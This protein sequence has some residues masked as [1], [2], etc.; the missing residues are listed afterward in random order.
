MDTD[1]ATSVQQAAESKLLKSLPLHNRTR[2]LRFPLRGCL[3]TRDDIGEDTPQAS[4]TVIAGPGVWPGFSMFIEDLADSLPSYYHRGLLRLPEAIPKPVHHLVHMEAQKCVELI[5]ALISWRLVDELMQCE[6]IDDGEFKV[7][8]SV[9][10]KPTQALTK[11]VAHLG[12]W[13]TV[14]QSASLA[15]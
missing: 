5:E 9:N 11:W 1:Y 14:L 8:Y 4:S 3:S 13:P 6:G 2:L 12:D 7:D 15:C 10:F